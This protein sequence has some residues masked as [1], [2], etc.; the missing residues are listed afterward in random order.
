MRGRRSELEWAKVV[1]VMTFAHR[2]CFD[3]YVLSIPVRRLS[4]RI[5]RKIGGNR[6]GRPVGKHHV[7]WSFINHMSVNSSTHVYT[8]SSVERQYLRH[9][10]LFMTTT[11]KSK[12]SFDVSSDISNAR[13]TF[14][15]VMNSSSARLF[16]PSRPNSSNPQF[17]KN[18]TV[19]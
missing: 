3:M 4:K 11:E 18:S 13:T 10:R 7:L 15:C 19:E 6:F 12:T 2:L 5:W 17:R 8:N 14:I 9:N 1:K 16:V